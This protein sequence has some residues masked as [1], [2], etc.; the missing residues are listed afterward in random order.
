MA[1]L[2][3]F[4]FLCLTVKAGKMEWNGMTSDEEDNVNMIFLD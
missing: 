2:Q 4:K 1:I 3:W